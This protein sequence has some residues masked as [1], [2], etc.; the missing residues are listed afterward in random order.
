MVGRESVSVVTSPA[1]ESVSTSGSARGMTLRKLA[2]VPVGGR[3]FCD[4][5]T[6]LRLAQGEAPGST[7]VEMNLPYG[8]LWSVVRTSDGYVVEGWASPTDVLKLANGGGAELFRSDDRY[9]GNGP[10]TPVQVAI[11]HLTHAVK[12]ASHNDAITVNP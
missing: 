8:E 12:S 1:S 4:A 9:S 5:D 2:D 7:M 6:L 11:D 10:G 3:F